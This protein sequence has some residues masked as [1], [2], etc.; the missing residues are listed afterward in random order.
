MF[1]RFPSH[2]TKLSPARIERYKKIMDS[3]TDTELDGL[4]PEHMSEARM[5]EIARGS[6]QDVKQVMEMLKEYKRLEK[7]WIKL[8]RYMS[9]STQM[10]M[11]A[12][13]WNEIAT[14]FHVETF[15]QPEYFPLRLPP[16]KLHPRKRQL[17]PNKSELVVLVKW[18][19]IL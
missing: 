4:N 18:A 3:M 7:V 13:F 12:L 8:E 15:T 10:D 11:S 16:R 19:L 14:P 1:S 9:D 5:K 2:K 17:P 6:R